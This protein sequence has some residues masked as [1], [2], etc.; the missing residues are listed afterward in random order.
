MITAENI[1]PPG[2]AVENWKRRGA[3]VYIDA[4]HESGRAVSVRVDTIPMI[5]EDGGKKE[6]WF[7]QVLELEIMRA[8]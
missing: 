3:G 4:K 7:K 2:W 6:V 1:L 8:L 5:F